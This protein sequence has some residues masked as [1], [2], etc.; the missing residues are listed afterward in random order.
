MTLRH[1]K[2]FVTVCEC[3]SVT[4]AANKLFIAQPT[5][6]LVIKELEEF[7]GVKLFDR[8][9][10]KLYITEPGKL[11]LNYATHIVS[12][13]EKMENEI[14][15][16]NSYG[17]LRL[18]S[19]ITIGN[20]L[21]PPLL[22]L[23]TNQ[24]PNVNSHVTIDN[25][26][27]IEE[28]VFKNKIDFGLIE[29]TVRNPQIKSEKFMNDELVLVC[30][31]GHP[32]FQQVDV[33][34]MKIKNYDFIL[35]EKGSGSRELFDST[36]LIHGVEIQPVI[37]SVSTQSIIRAVSSGI[38]LTLLPYLLVKT[39]ISKGN[40]H[41]INI[42]GIVF[43]RNYYIIYH[44]NKYFTQPAKYFIELCHNTSVVNNLLK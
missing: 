24:F 42:R 4:E 7:Y 35:R 27:K 43:Q 30:G 44:Q 22:Q 1:I 39:D 16:S 29:G 9:S 32:L 12:L 5:V 2:I 37:E 38:G 28:L 8:I 41:K 3:G 23:F 13:F 14:K 25:S 20:Y 19:S 17:T 15:N 34:L 11:F 33:G 6:S 10:R 18:G 21:I 36:M 26:R 40:L 31:K